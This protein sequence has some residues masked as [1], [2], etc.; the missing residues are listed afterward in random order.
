[1]SSQ[2]Q[3][4]N[5]KGSTIYRYAIVGALGI[6]ALIGCA[7]FVR[8]RID[9]RRRVRNGPPLGVGGD[10][11]ALADRPR[12]YEAYLGSIQGAWTDYGWQDIM[13]L[14]LHSGGSWP[15]NSNKH[16]STDVDPLTS[17]QSRIAMIIAM[18]S[19]RGAPPGPT[20]TPLQSPSSEDDL[21][22]PYFEIGITDV[23]VRVEQR[24]SLNS[25]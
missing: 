13:P 18:P 12:L 6:V 8:S 5:P 3:P 23:D 16:V 2:S 1:M 9:E 7:L 10:A 25:G 4:F 15:Q 24:E 14:S 11:S 21:T 22:L 20:H 17:A 19:R